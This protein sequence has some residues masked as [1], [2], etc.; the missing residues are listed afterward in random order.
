MIMITNITM[1]IRI[2]TATVIV[3]A[4][5]KVILSLDKGGFTMAVFV[6]V[7]VDLLI[8]GVHA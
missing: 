7:V 6:S 4:T 2:R 5:I 8:L 3:V 1:I